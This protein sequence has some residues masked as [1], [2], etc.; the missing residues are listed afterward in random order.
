MLNIE[1]L[2]NAIQALE[3]AIQRETNGSARHADVQEAPHA[4]CT[5]Y[6]QGPSQVKRLCIICGKKR[7]EDPE[8]ESTS[9]VHRACVRT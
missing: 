2:D 1:G 5:V 8:P 4:V 9:P 3:S 6:R 7:F